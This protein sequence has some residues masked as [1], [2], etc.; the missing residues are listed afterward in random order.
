LIFR[1]LFTFTYQTKCFKTKLLLHISL[2]QKQLKL[3]RSC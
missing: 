1:I 3:T 2:E